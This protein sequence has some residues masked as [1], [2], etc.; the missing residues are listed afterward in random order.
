[1]VPTSPIC[2]RHIGLQ[3]K[4]LTWR[5]LRWPEPRCSQLQVLVSEPAKG[6]LSRHLLR[7][8]QEP[9]LRLGRQGNCCGSPQSLAPQAAQCRLKFPPRF[10]WSRHRTDQTGARPSEKLRRPQHIRQVQA[11]GTELWPIRT[12]RLKPVGPPDPPH[13]NV[14]ESKSTASIPRG[15]EC[16]TA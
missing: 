10:P 9:R 6:L 11:M 16:Q 4:W 12:K 15:P 7:F 8:W 1:M 2:Q 14:G 5:G 13:I 3:T